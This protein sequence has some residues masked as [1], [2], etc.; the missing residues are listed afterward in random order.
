MTRISILMS[1]QRTEDLLFLPTIVLF[2]VSIA[3]TCLGLAFSETVAWAG[4]GGMCLAGVPAFY[5]GIL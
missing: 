1:S 2:L 3:A 4:I 5:Y